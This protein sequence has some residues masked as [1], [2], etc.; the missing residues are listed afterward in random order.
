MMA[1]FAGHAY[2]QVP[3]KILPEVGKPMPDFKLTDV[4]YYKKKRATLADFKGQWL[5][6][7]FWNQY[8]GV[9][10]A[11]QPRMDT[12]QKKFAGRVQV[13]LIGYTGSQ[14]IHVSNDKSIRKLYERNRIENKLSLAIAFDSL[15]M[16]AYRIKPTPYIIVIDPDGIVRAITTRIT[17][18]S[19]DDLIAGRAA[20]LTNAY[21]SREEARKVRLEKE[22][23]ARRDSTDKAN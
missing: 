16:H 12:L 14:Y 23:R 3:E 20:A 22:A 11:S 13:L 4:H 1:F 17:V 15:L 7:D 18:K 5:I 2:A 6:M 10:L 9:C 19:L 21:H 8:C